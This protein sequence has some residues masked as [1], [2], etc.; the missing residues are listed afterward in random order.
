M[1]LSQS[2]L[3]ELL[4]AIRAG[5][6]DDVLREAMTLVLQEL[7]ELEAARSSVPGGTS[8][9][10]VGRRTATAAAAGYRAGHRSRGF[11]ERHVAFDAL[12]ADP[13]S[14]GCFRPPIPAVGRAV[15]R[16]NID[17]VAD[18]N[19][20]DRD[21]R[22]QAAVAPARCDSQL[23]R[24]PDPLELV[25]APRGH[26]DTAFGGARYS[27]SPTWSPNSLSGPSTG[28]SQIAR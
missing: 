12:S 23:G 27:P 4:G 21:V 7:I 18:S 20:P 25:G 17:F 28:A 13:P 22:P 15:G 2:A 16:T 6:S 8:G 9:P 3:S 24:A 5:G 1:A 19:D 14:A 26:R 11:L 10:T